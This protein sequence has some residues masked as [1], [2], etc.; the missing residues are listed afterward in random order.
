MAITEFQR[1]ICRLIAQSRVQQGDSYVAGG[2]ALN[3]LIGASRVSRD[4]D[5]FHDTREALAATWDADR[6]QLIGHGYGVDVRRERPTFVEAVVT[7]GEQSVVL[8]WVCDSAY[9]FFPLMEHPDFGLTLHPFDL[10]TNKVLALVGRIE[11]RDWVD[12]I[13]CSD[14]LQ[15][16]GYLAWAACGKDP[17]YGPAV[18][19]AEGKRTGRY[20]AAEV[21]ELA[22]DGPVPDASQLSV[23]WGEILREAHEI[24]D[25]LPVQE[26][27][28]CVMSKQGG[29]FSGT[30]EDATRALTAQELVFHTGSIRGAMPSCVAP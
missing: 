22:F 9:R 21:A 18:L 8:E 6:N 23:R 15:H 20:S 27:G 16:L 30:A 10:A 1:G 2:V 17:G 3:T 24:I 28:R 19:L 25:S 4:I 13:S 12:T 5:L 14:R 11:V 7:R 29:L 26:V